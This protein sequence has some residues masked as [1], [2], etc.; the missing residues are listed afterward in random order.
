[1]DADTVNGDFF[2][3]NGH[4]S[5]LHLAVGIV[6]VSIGFHIIL[7]VIVSGIFPGSQ[8]HKAS[9]PLIRFVQTVHQSAADCGGILHKVLIFAIIGQIRGKVHSGGC[10]RLDLEIRRGSPSADGDF[11]SVLAHINRR[12]IAFGISRAV[13]TLILY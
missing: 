9:L 11:G 2:L 10:D 3:L 5:G 4:S 7:D 8:H 1:M 6:R 12:G 13:P